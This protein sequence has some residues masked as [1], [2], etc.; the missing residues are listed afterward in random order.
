[1]MAVNTTGR[2]GT[3]PEDDEALHR[4]AIA[5]ASRRLIPFLMLMF[6]L[7][8]IDRVNISFAALQMNHELGLTPAQ[9]GFAAG[10]FFIAYL[11]CEIPSNLILERV[12]AGPMAG[13]DHDHLGA[14]C[15][16][17]RV[18]LRQ[19][20]AVDGARP[21]GCRRGR[22]RAGRDGLPDALVP[23]CGPWQGS[24]H[25][26]GRQSDRQHRRWSDL[27][28]HSLDGWVLGLSGLALAVSSSKAFPRSSSALRPCGG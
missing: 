22:I 3:A 18:R 16:R 4:A 2:V 5:K 10:L 14:C 17:H 11:V 9:Y 8:T 7:N 25:L 23:R 12:G 6:A 24:N 21:A 1:M 26:S 15:D 27:G 20:L 19:L 13:A 28:R